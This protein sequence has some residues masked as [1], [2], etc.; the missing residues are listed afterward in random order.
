MEIIL[1]QDLD[2]LGL[3]GDIVNVAKGYARNY[4]IPKAIAL[5]A[6]PQNIKALELQRKKIEVSRLK[7]R[8][9]AEKLKQKMEG[10]KVTFAHKAGEEGKLYGSVTSTDIASQ[11][12]K[13]DIVI[14]RKKVLLEKPIKTLGECDVRVRIYPEV[15]GSIKVVVVPEKGKDE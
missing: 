15:T 5:E 13:H 11:L 14:D 7:A 9:E 6:S 8:E 10:L 4:L 1:Q 12:E 3:H 2:G